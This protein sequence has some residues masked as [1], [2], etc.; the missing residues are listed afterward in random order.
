MRASSLR[1]LLID[2]N[3]HGLVARRAV[4]EQLGH[5]V[6]VAS[7]GQDGIDQ[8]HEQPFDLVVTDYRMPEVSGQ[9][10]I[11]KLRQQS[12]KVPII[13]LSGYVEALGITEQSTGADV[14]LSKGPGE[15]QALL[16]AVARLGKRKPS[17]KPTKP[18]GKPPGAARAS[19]SK[20]A[21]ARTAKAG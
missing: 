9:Q 8:F 1:I 11:R 17:A 4:L 13:L 21:R 10:V 14:V 12:P 16:R 18:A 5:K 2:D 19:K 15:V 20:T 3:R 6:S 7:G